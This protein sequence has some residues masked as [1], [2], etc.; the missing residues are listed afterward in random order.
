M[1]QGSFASLLNGRIVAAAAVPVLTASGGPYSAPALEAH[2]R[3]AF[4]AQH[5]RLLPLFELA[6]VVFT[7]ADETTGRFVV[8]V[9]DQE[10]RGLIRARLSAL[11]VPF[12]SVDI[13]ETD[14]IL[15]LASPRD[16]VRPAVGGLQ[17]PLQE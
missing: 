4:E 6:G 5:Q 13:V 14:A 2:G 12:E 3:P 11:G 16:F 7:D 9:Q 10:I 8:G 1:S 15:P 17:I